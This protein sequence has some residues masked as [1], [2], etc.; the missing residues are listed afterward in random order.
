MSELIADLFVSVDGHAR[1][2]RSPGY[3]GFGGPGL[4][5]WVQAQSERPQR[6][7]M[8]RKTYAA[9]AGL[10]EE[11][12]DEGWHGMAATPTTVFSRTLQDAS[13]P[14]TTISDDLVGTVRRLKAE[15]SALRTIGSLSVVRQLLHAG[16]VDRLRLMVFPLII[17]ATGQEPAFARLPDVALDLVGQSVI[18]G[19]IV[20][21]EYRPSGE[22]PYAG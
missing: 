18:D 21:L 4:D 1:G 2:E 14:Y 15:D 17:G 19:R 12:R 10:P 22:P 11:L 13:W 16:L 20:V 8:G 6:H 7:I 3:F 5:R 9:L